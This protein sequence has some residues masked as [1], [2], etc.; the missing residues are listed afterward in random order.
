MKTYWSGYIH[1]AIIANKEITMDRHVL[2]YS[3]FGAGPPSIQPQKQPVEVEKEE[4]SSSCT[5]DEFTEE[6]WEYIESVEQEV[7][8]QQEVYERQK[9][10]NDFAMRTIAFGI[11]GLIF[12]EA[13]R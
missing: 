4:F 6:D 1:D 13:T 10:A 9:S 2:L 5:D 12:H 3:V 7:R 8:E 11:A